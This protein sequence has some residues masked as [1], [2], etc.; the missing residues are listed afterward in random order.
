ML[1]VDPLDE[2][3]S[4]YAR[5]AQRPPLLLSADDRR[6]LR[7]FHTE[8]ALT[9][10]P[11]RRLEHRTIETRWLL[12]VFELT[13]FVK[14]EGRWPRENNRDPRPPISDEEK[15]LAGWVRTH[16]RSVRNGESCT[17]Q[18]QRPAC[19]PG[20]TLDPHGDR[21]ATQFA[22]YRQ[23]VEHEHRAPRE[24]ITVLQE[25]GDGQPERTDDEGERASANWAAKQRHKHRRGTL[26]PERTS[27]LEDYRRSGGI[28]H[29]GPRQ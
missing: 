25:R 2:L 27:A 9:A 21:W 17:Y 8:T 4:R 11:G 16:R 6:S 13:D 29:W 12:T 18:Q 28:W 23:F 7:F 10:D 22:A 14:R 26:P 3:H 24:H 5:I 1:P 20:Y 15:R 19:I